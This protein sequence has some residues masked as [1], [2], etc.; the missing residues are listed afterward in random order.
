MVEDGQFLKGVPGAG[1]I[2][3]LCLCSWPEMVIQ[4]P[5]GRAAVRKFAPMKVFRVMVFPSS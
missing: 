5:F 2:S 4:G 1:R 3:V